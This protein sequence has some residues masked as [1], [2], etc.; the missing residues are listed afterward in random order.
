MYHSSRVLIFCL[1]VSFPFLAGA[2][3]TGNS[4]FS[5]FG[6]G[7]L[8]FNNGNLRNIG[9]GYSGI[10]SRHHEYVNFINPALLPN[11]RSPRTSRLN[12]TYRNW[13]HYRNLKVD[14]TV[15]IDFALQY[16]NRSIQTPNGYENASGMNV[17]YLTFSMPLSKTWGTSLGIVPFSSVNYNIVY[18]EPV[19][20]KPAQ[21][22]SVQNKGTGGLYKIF[23]SNGV[24]ITK[25]LSVGLETAFLYGNINNE[26]FSTVSDISTKNFGFSRQTTYSSFGFK[27][28]VLFRREIIKSYY[29]TTYRA[30]SS[31][32][33]TVPEIIKKTKSTGAFYNFALTYDMFTT[34]NI[35][36]S[37]N[38]YV[39]DASNRIAMD[40]TVETN[41]Y[42]TK[43]PSTLRLGFSLD[44]P[45]CWAFSADAFYTPWSNYSTGF[46][47]DTLA[48][49]YGFSIGGEYTRCPYD[50]K[51]N[52]RVV[53]ETSKTYRIGFS[54][55]KTP[56]IYRNRQLDDVSFSI[57]GTLPLG[58]KKRDHSERI[59]MPVRPKFCPGI[60][61]ARQ[62]WRFR[63]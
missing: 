32:R 49:A 30:D 15:K 56:V 26:L 46:S 1:L 59:T 35:A 44:E 45:M 29:D 42:T 31:G 62:L 16:Q 60:W 57:C 10:S 58:K 37:L 43:L 7:D 48:N 53:K 47:T 36:R 8:L 39:L 22:A 54:Y 63:D 3:G 12:H 41:K 40:T 52:K 23:L 51:N 20:G 9:M 6:V 55:M 4:P 24:G 18:N 17:A 38:L 5:Q 2:Q 19:I 21:T 61:S 25:N 34:M 27:P 11:L 14:S 28:G 13:D 33:L 50:K